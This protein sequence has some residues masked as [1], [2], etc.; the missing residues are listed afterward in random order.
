MKCKNTS[1]IRNAVREILSAASRLKECAKI[2]MY[3]DM[4]GDI[5]V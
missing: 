4:N 1:E 3:A 2:N 5:G